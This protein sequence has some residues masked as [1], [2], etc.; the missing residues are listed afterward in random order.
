MDTTK[1]I[2]ILLYDF[3]LGTIV[4]LEVILVTYATLKITERN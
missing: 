4:V 2:S 1:H 3:T